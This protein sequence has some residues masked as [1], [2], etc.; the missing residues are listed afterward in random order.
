MSLKKKL[1]VGLVSAT[2]GLS[3][4]GGEHMHILA[5]KR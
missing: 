5:T 3:L 4:I 1:G 2:L